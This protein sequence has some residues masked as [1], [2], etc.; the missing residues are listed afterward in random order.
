MCRRGRC[1]DG[2]RSPAAK[3]EASQFFSLFTF[4]VLRV[5]AP[6]S[7]SRMPATPVRRPP[8]AGEHTDE[9]LQQIGYSA[10]QI[11]DLRA[12]GIV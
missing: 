12:K 2:R 1:D 8:T 11:A 4:H 3:I 5:A 6:I 7:M 10:Q 9:L